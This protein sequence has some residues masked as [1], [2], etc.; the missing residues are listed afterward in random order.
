MAFF[1][2][3]AAGLVKSDITKF[4]G[5][6]GNV[7]F[8][9]ETGQMYLSDGVT[10]GGIPIT[11]GGGGGG[12]NT[13]NYYVN[14]NIIGSVSDLNDLP[15]N[16]NQN[17]AVVYT[18][19]QHLYVWDGTQW[20]DLGHIQGP[21]GA[22]GP[23]GPTGPSVGT[24]VIVA[25]VVP[26][27]PT[28]GTV[29]FNT[30]NGTLYVYYDGVW[31]DATP[32]FLGPTGSTGQQGPTGAASTAPG[33][34]GPTGATGETGATG[35]TGPTGATGATGASVT[36]PTGYDG[37]DG[38]TGPTGA[39]GASVTG[40]TG[41]TGPQG[42]TGAT[43]PVDNYV[44]WLAAGTGVSISGPT[45]QGATPTISIGQ[46]VGLTDS[47]NFANLTLTDNNTPEYD[48][49]ALLRYN[50]LFIQ[51]ETNLFITNT[52]PNLIYNP[53][54]YNAHIYDV[55][56]ATIFDLTYG[57]N[58]KS[59]E[60]GSYYYD[61]N[62]RPIDID[63]YQSEAA[64]IMVYIKGLINDVLNNNPVAH[65]YQYDY[66]QV[67]DPARI[68]SITDKGII[69]GSIDI[70]INTINTGSSPTVVPPSKGVI[71]FGDGRI[72]R[73]VS[74]KMFTANDFLY[75]GLVVD[76]ILPGDFLY[77]YTSSSIFIMVDSGYGYNTLLDLTQRG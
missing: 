1:R 55:I 12:G 26:T 39:T 4:V 68:P 63:I 51:T 40:P 64:A 24:G 27:G 19:N 70:I 47:V 11:M 43:G 23:T 29:W 3:I 61:T 69:A 41:W 15:P 52:Y 59:I 46:P 75:G 58:S 62:R 38:P 17:D 35:Y 21:P 36:G 48:T 31:I 56:E 16:A 13:N 42:A 49:R 32:S 54:V 44:K 14:F 6:I 77:D 45:G 22:T 5:E 20:L 2:K 18:V 9:I 57:G 50:K 67:I 72:Q 65:V 33:Q 73:T 28:L 30:N 10:P 7:F 8:N 37:K 74:A 34:T 76:D 71:K 25:S 60:V 66:P 53:A